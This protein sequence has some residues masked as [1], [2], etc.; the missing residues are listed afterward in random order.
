MQSL[1]SHHSKFLIGI[2][3]ITWLTEN[4]W[5][6][7]VWPVSVS[8]KD[9]A[10]M[11]SLLPSLGEDTE[12]FAKDVEALSIEQ[13]PY[14][15]AI[16]EVDSSKRFCSSQITS[17]CR[18]DLGRYRSG[19]PSERQVVTGRKNDPIA[20]NARPLREFSSIA[21]KSPSSRNAQSKFSCVC[22]TVKNGVV[23][24]RSSIG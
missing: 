16:H 17:R 14:R 2:A 22:I 10:A 11:M 6:A 23:R 3:T 8:M 21:A 20:T 7:P 9:F 24:I 1:S 19:V 15:G 13:I 18:G 4:R 12:S 5:V